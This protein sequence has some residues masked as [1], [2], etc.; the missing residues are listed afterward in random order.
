M[1]LVHSTPLLWL[2]FAAPL[3]VVA[4]GCGSPSST[5]NGTCPLDP[6]CYEVQPSGECSL[7]SNAVCVA[8]AWQCS[9]HGTLGSGC[10]PDGGVAPPPAPQS[11]GGTCPLATLQPP[12]ACTSDATCTPYGGHCEFS[13]LNGPGACVCGSIAVD[14]GCIGAQCGV[15]TLPLFV[16]SCSGTSDPSCSHYGDAYCAP[17]MSG[18]QYQCEC[19]AP[20]PSSECTQACVLSC[21]PATATCS[22]GADGGPEC[23]CILKGGG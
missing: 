9:A 4:S 23:V 18:P 3:A 15:C 16:V 2:P 10:L 22:V 7:D 11:D 8:G 5:S 1:K 21:L 14:S 17:A 6:A 20:G 19:Q 12:L 13:G